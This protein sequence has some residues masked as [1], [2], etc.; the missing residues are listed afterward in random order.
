MNAAAVDLAGSLAG[1]TDVEILEQRELA[2]SPKLESLSDAILYAKNFEAYFSDH[3]LVR[4]RLIIVDRWMRVNLFDQRYFEEIA[5]TDEGWLFYS[6][7]IM[8][9]DCQRTAVFTQ[10]ELRRMQSAMLKAV[11]V[12]EENGIELHYLIAPNK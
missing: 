2:E 6:Q 8:S 5:I 4:N 9:D 12:A 3:F 1:I 7:P 10:R 11:D